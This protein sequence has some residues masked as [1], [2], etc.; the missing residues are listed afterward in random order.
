M[1]KFTYLLT[2]AAL[3]FAACQSQSSYNITGTFSVD[4]PDGVFTDSVKVVLRTNNGVEEGQVLDS[5]Y[6]V[7]KTFTFKGQ[8][9]DSV[10]SAYALL[11][12][13]GSK[14]PF[15]A[16]YFY[17]E[18]GNLN[19]Q[20]TENGTI[21]SG[22]P[23]NE[24]Y[25]SYT[26]KIT[27]IQQPLTEIFQALADTSL[28]EEAKNAKR[29]EFREARETV[30]EEMNTTTRTFIRNNINNIVGFSLLC[31]N[32]SVF[33]IEE[34]DSLFGILPANFANTQIAQDIKTRIDITKKTAIGQQF[35]DFTLKTPEGDD[36]KLSDIVAKNKVT[37]VDFW[38]S[39]CGPCRAEM[40]NVVKAYKDFKK[41]GF[42][43]VGVSLDSD[44]EAWKKAIKDLNL[45]WPQMSDL[46]GWKCEGATLYNIRSIPA[47]VLISQNGEILAKDL[48]GEELGKK[49]SEVLK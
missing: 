49:L 46:Q 44:A 12:R 45:T 10:Q 9:P 36:L 19:I 47:T 33:S 28:T 20:I 22:T 37:L 26:S 18:S 8:A 27:E 39:W 30:S 43:I 42:E 6:I 5:T 11:Y 17:L 23:T 35:T 1:K 13:E 2:G 3:L 25:N 48:R 41:K 31:N 24:L 15:R 21:L 38:A 34:Q 40:P 7:D 4:D 32:Y 29:E 16:I 14:R